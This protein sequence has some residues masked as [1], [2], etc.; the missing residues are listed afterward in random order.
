MVLFISG[1]SFENKTKQEIQY[2][3]HKLNYRQRIN[4]DF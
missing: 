3:Q 4:L 2:V 1:S